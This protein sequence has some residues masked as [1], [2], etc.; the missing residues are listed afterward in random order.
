M[1]I[2]DFKCPTCEGYIPNNNTIGAYSGALSRHGHGEVCSA[3]G[4]K[5]ALAD[6]IAKGA[7]L[8]ANSNWFK[9]HIQIIL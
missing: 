2:E 6:Y 8:D 4:T 3:C 9:N 1:I 7:G 5:E